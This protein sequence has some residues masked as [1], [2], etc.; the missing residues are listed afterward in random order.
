MN[1][2]DVHANDEDALLVR[3]FNSGEKPA[4]DKLVLKYK[5]KVF[6]IC[7]R[8]LN[9]YEEANDC[10]Q[11][12]FVKIYRS[13]K[14]FRFE[15]SFSTWLYRIAVNTCKN[16][17][18]SLEYRF[19]K[20][21]VRLDSPVGDSEEKSCPLEIGSESLSPEVGIDRIEKYK[22]IEQAIDSL[23]QDQ[24]TVVIL[25]DIQLLSYEEIAKI[26]GYNLGTV[27]SKLSRARQ[28]LRERLKGADINGMHKG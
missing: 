3:A 11:E 12:T 27:K 19:K 4:F 8:F 23:P 2:Q 6:N 22:I 17:I 14:N 9:D 15:S 25:R 16:K 7:Y 28:A 24:K 26:T 21:M 13:L 18:T 1:R 10:A 5:D 20:K